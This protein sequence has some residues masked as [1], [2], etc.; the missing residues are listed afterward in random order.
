MSVRV[1]VDM[2]ATLL[3]HGHVRLLKKAAEYGEV[4]VG[5]NSD[6]EIEKYKGYKPL[7]TWE[8]R[9]EILES[10]KYV[11]DVVEIPYYATDAVLDKHNVQY[12]IHGEDNLNPVSNDRLII[13][14]RTPNISSS[15]LR[16][17]VYKSEVNNQPADSDVGNVGVK[18]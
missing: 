7:L 11:S 17:R 18:N 3:H 10:I 9:K 1:M 15:I 2:S 16:N 8:A 4:I 12:L 13:I 14:S 6:Y 5:L